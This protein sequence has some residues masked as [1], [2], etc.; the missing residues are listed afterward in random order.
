LIAAEAN[1]SMNIATLR[2]VRR[3]ARSGDTER[4]WRLFEGSGLLSETGDADVLSLKGRL[5]K[6]R[7]LKAAAADQA[8]LFGA[9]RDAYL[10][11]A[12]VSPATYPLINAATIELLGGDRARSRDL[13][14]RIVDMLD[15]GAHEPET[16]YWLGAT[17]AEA[18]LLL[19]R[20]ADAQKALGDA[21]AEAPAAWE[22]HASTLR[23][24]RLILDAL[25]QSAEWL[26]A[27]RPPACIHFSGI[28]HLTDGGGVRDAIAAEL[29][30]IRPGFAYGALAAGTDIIAAE[31]LVDQGAELHIVLPSSIAAFRRDSVARFGDQWVVRFNR[32]LDAA[33]SVET[34]GES[35]IVSE[36]GIVMADQIAMG[37]AIRQ[38][39]ILEGSAIALRI[40]DPNWSRPSAR[41]LDAAWEAQGLPVHRIPAARSEYPSL[42]LPSLAREVALALPVGH[43]LD[44]LLAAGGSLGEV[45]DNIVAI[46]FAEPAVAARAA[47]A[48]IAG[49]DGAKIPVG[50]DYGLFDPEDPA[51]SPFDGARTIAMSALPGK[52]F[53]SR[54]AALAL[55]LTAPDLGCE[56]FG[57]IATAR[58]NVALSIIAG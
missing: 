44:G 10:Q 47:V 58:G 28:I 4:A 54:S 33:M 20:I 3:L 36:A 38:A 51:M 17:R 32:L 57:E 52:I 5:I 21:V 45:R 39:C 53:A 19:D 48:L 6:D 40:G 2:S 15:S 13:A 35:E 50:L 25:G 29:D 49:S 34:V 7:A 18:Y 26:D 56:N 11:A 8:Q 42:P 1:E 55:V 12:S 41:P 37:L 46:R 30:A 23:H 43:P 22:D 24:F 9:A 14:T 16:P 27:H 31:I